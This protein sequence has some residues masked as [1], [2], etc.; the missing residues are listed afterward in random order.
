MPYAVFPGAGNITIRFEAM[1]RPDFASFEHVSPPWVKEAG[2]RVENKGTVIEFQTDSSSGYHDFRDGN[3]IVL[4][5]LA[6]KSDAATYNPPGTEKGDKPKITKLGASN[7]AT[8]A[9]AGTIADTAAK[10][11]ADAPPSQAATKPPAPVTPSLAPAATAAA[12]PQ[13]QR[14]RRRHK[15]PQR[16]L[17]RRPPPQR[18][19][20]HL[21]FPHPPTK[22]RRNA[23]MRAPL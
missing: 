21:R 19:R 13:L 15:P 7:A 2:W 6:P 10:L 4:D 17:L 22:R 9:Q 3:K 1:V 23:R 14:L 16:K 18:L 12:A 11:K 8:A 20:G 5:I